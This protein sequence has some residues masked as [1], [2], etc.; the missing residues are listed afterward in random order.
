MMYGSY[1]F[2]K[3]GR[4]TIT[5]LNGNVL[6]PRQ[7]R[8]SSLDIAGTNSIYPIGNTGGETSACDGVAEWS[9]TTRYFVG[10][11]VTYRGNLFERDFTRWTF[12]KQC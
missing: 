5:D 11:R 6:A 10:D 12:I 8:I 4:P 2:S 9:P 1:T 3:N 7:A